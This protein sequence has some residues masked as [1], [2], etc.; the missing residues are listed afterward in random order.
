[1]DPSEEGKEVKMSD[2]DE[3]DRARSSRPYDEKEEKDEK[4]VQ[5]RDEKEDQS[6]EEKWQRDPLN[7]ATW[8]LI[9]IWAGISFL[10]GNLGL[11]NRLEPLEAWDIVLIGAGLLLL[12]QVAVRLLIPEYRQPVMGTS[13]LAVVLLG[14]GLG[15]IVGWGAL[16]PVIL[17]VIGVGILARGLLNK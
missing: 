8:A 6:W 2:G 10:L 7:A 4:E 3:R 13:I 9:L 14:L 15:D 11:W 12:I 16:W 17:I 1:M 5:K